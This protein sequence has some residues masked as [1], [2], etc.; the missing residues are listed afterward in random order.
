MAHSGSRPAG[1]GAADQP[2]SAFSGAPRSAILQTIQPTGQAM[3]RAATAALLMLISTVA[4]NPAAAG[5]TINCPFNGTTVAAVI[6]NSKDLPRSCHATCVWYYAN[7]P[8][9]GTGGAVL[10]IGE[11]KTIYHATAPVKIDGVAGSGITCNQ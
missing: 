4:A 5:A 2:Q 3:P 6:V 8:F 11:S 1:D 9:R 7:M 10:A